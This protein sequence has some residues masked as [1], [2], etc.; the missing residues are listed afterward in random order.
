MKRFSRR[1]SWPL[2]LWLGSLLCSAQTNTV[3]GP[4]LFT[5]FVGNGEDGLHLAASDDGLHWEPLNE[6]NSV[7]GAKVGISKLMRDPNVVLGP[8][9]VYHLVWTAG[10]HENDIGHAS[11][12]DFINWSEEEAIPVMKAEPNVQNTWAPEAVWDVERKEYVVFW[13]SSIVGKYSAKSGGAKPVLDH[14]IYFSTTKDWQ[15]F[16][17]AKLF[18]DPGFSV[19][20]ATIFTDGSRYHLLVKDETESPPKKHLR[21]ASSS[22]ATGPWTNLLAPFTRD[23]VEGPTAIKVGREWL[24][25]YD[26]YRERHFGALRSADLKQWEDVTA[27]IS[28]PDGAR[29]GTMFPVPAALLA[30]LKTHYGA[31]LPTAEEIDSKLPTL[32]VAGDST[33]AH[34]P[35]EQTGWGVPFAA[36]LDSS[37]INYR[38]LARGGRSSRTFITEGLWTNLVSQVKAGDIVLIQFGHND[39]GPI[40]DET[41]ARG[42]LP[43]LGD[44]T[45]SIDNLLTHKPEV[46]HTYGSYM[47]QMIEDVKAKNARPIV[48]SLTVRNVWKDN[49]VE[50]NNGGYRRWSRELASAEGVAFV[51]VTRIL[52]D[53]YQVLGPGKVAEFFPKDHTHTNVA[54]A[55]YSAAAILGGLKG[56]RPSPLSEPVLSEKGRSVRADTVGWLNLP[57]PNDPKL[58]SLIL[59]GDSTVRNGRGDGAGGQWGWGDELS[60]KFDPKKINV[61]NRAVGGLSSRTFLTQGHWTRTL[62]LMKKGDV[63]VMQFGHNDAAPLNDTSRARGTIPGVGEE[64]EEIDNQLTHQHEVVHSYGWYLRRYIQEAKERGAYPV[65]CSPIPRKRWSGDK[66][67]RADKDYG[68]WAKSVAETEHVP[69]VD[70]NNLIAARYEAIGRAAVEPLFADEHTHTSKIGAELNADVVW[71]ALQQLEALPTWLREA[72]AAQNN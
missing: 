57:E 55:E 61:V 15:T 44:E 32:F 28:V 34:G 53:E 47:R 70:L 24:V 50:R 39:A 52:A 60:V 67:E 43:G 49:I 6:G 63:V 3:G 38:N 36:F 65:V 31:H 11:T 16:S 46:V 66:I 8:D 56:L 71:K 18:Y 59:I 2:W 48:M 5:Y 29:H 72:D 33:A 64:Q 7:L 54:G 4:W 68:T 40:N 37:K 41:R 27:K 14:R 23:W 42:T 45:K 13:A 69:F 22:K 12:K 35:P 58:P 25:Y 20:D 17:P 26:C 62:T 9:G 21:I 51:D 10:W 1:W 19:I 30:A